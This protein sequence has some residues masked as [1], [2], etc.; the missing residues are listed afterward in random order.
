MNERDISQPIKSWPTTKIRAALVSGCDWLPVRQRFSVHHTFFVRV[1]QDYLSYL[2]VLC[3]M[4]RL[5]RSF[6]MGKSCGIRSASSSTTDS[7]EVL[8]SGFQIVWR[9]LGYFFC[10]V[11]FTGKEDRPKIKRSGCQRLSKQHFSLICEIK[12]IDLAFFY[13]FQ[14]MAVPTSKVDSLSSQKCKLLSHFSFRSI[15]DGRNH[16]SQA[17]QSRT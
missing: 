12:H 13:S 3:G 15:E 14:S 9:L 10:V 2:V 4:V 6:A 8:R 17:G 5:L 16:R 11:R 7:S 1:C